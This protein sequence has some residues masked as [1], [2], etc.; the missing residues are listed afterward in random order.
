MKRPRG[1]RPTP[2]IELTGVTEVVEKPSAQSGLKFTT[3]PVVP[4]KG[5]NDAVLQSPSVDLKTQALMYYIHYH[6]QTLKDAPNMSKG[7]F[8]DLLPT[9]IS[10]PECPILDLTISSMALAAFSRTKN[11]PLAGVQASRQYHRLLQIAQATIPSLNEGNLDACLLAI[12]F[13]GRYEEV[14]HRPYHFSSKNSLATALQSFSHHDGAL[15]TMKIWKD[16]LSHSQPATDIVKHTRRGLLRSALLRNL[17]FP[18]WMLEGSFFGEYGLELEYDRIVVQIADVRQRLSKLLK[19]VTG[20]P[21]T[22]HEL[23]STAEDINKKAQ[24]IDKALEDWMAQ[25]PSTWS[26]QQHTLPDPHP[27]PMRDFYS[28]IVYS[29]SSP[30]YAAVWNQYHATRMLI[31]STRLKILQFICSNSNTFAPEQRLICLSRI[32]NLAND[33]ASSLPYCLQRIKVVDSSKSSSQRK[34]ITLNTN[35]DIKPYLATLTVWPLTIASSLGDVDA[36]QAMW[37]KS[38]LSRLGKVV[39]VGVFQCAE[40][41]QWLEL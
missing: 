15:A 34:S 29:Y 3:V 41:D 24:T 18:A 12:V 30:A 39:G 26:Y 14:I 19:K 20:L 6:L 21:R 16:H 4:K 1:P 10:R 7:I 9:W 22:F 13:M 33:L 27:W 11:H 17:A 8:D 31:N 32:R 2:T 40:T 37:F 25:F 5:N 28:P 35:E 36:K 23:T 38:E